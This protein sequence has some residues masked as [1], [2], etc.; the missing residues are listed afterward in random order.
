MS[1]LLLGRLPS[2]ISIA[3]VDTSKMNNLREKLTNTA[4]DAM[5][6]GIALYNSPT[7]PSY[8]PEGFTILAISGW[9]HLLK[10]KWLEA[11]NDD[12]ASLYRRYAPK[13][14][15]RPVTVGVHALAKKMREC[16]MLPR[17]IH[18]NLIGLNEVRNDVAH[19]V[20]ES[21]QLARKVHEFATANVEN[22]ALLLNEW[23][24]RDMSAEYEFAL[25]PLA[26]ENTVAISVNEDVQNLLD[27]WAELELNADAA[28][29]K[30]RVSRKVKVVMDEDADAGTNIRITDDSRVPALYISEEKW[31]QLYP[32]THKMVEDFCRDRYR[33]FKAGMGKNGR[34]ETFNDLCKE[35]KGRGVHSNFAGWRPGSAEEPKDPE[36]ARKWRKQGQWRYSRNVVDFFD[37]HY[38]LQNP[39]EPSE[40]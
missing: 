16:E 1:V 23:F 10:A 26:F 13:E 19:L 7:T 11:H 8:R 28:D 32:W 38:T 40:E 35:L 34:G 20:D 37:Q 9:E 6:C 25:I 12:K 3:I 18:D 17:N 36:K 30:Y 39:D 27:F 31:L 14:G 2:P 21:G 4:V 33:D 22:F 15:R 24:N 5:V 29:M